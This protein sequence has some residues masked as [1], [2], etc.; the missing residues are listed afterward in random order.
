MITADVRALS[1][2]HL[3]EDAKNLFATSSAT[4]RA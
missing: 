1:A 4:A 2:G 3:A